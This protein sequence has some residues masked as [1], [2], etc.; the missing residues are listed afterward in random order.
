MPTQRK[1]AARAPTKRTAKR[2]PAKATT[3]KRTA[4]KATTAKR[5]PGKSATAKRTQTKAATATT[6]R[7]SARAAKG[8]HTAPKNR[9]KHTAPKPTGTR[10]SARTA[11]TGPPPWWRRA[12]SGDRPLLVAM[13][14]VLAVFVAMLLGPLHSFTSA[15]ERVDA[16]EARKT[17][18]TAAVD[19]LEQRRSHL[20]DPEHVEL[21]AREELGMVRP[22]EVPYVVTGQKGDVEKLPRLDPSGPAPPKSWWERLSAAFSRML[23]RS[24][25]K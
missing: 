21:L 18:L 13:F 19:E 20:L 15:S 2:A 4:A 25:A 23:D 1:P 22:G 10:R 6:A 7:T 9:G 17:E 8:K 11:R 14:A 24:R 3:A 5:T 16:L 12:L